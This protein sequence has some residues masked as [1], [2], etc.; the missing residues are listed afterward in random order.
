MD[1]TTDEEIKKIIND[2]IEIR[3]RKSTFKFFE[4]PSN[5]E[6]A[7]FYLVLAFVFSM[8]FLGF[9]IMFAQTMIDEAKNYQKAE[10]IDL[11]HMSC[12]ELKSSLTELKTS[13]YYGSSENTKDEITA[14][15]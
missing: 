15:C 14:R 10:Q 2:T 8:I 6:S 3:K 7:F 1:M 5:A 13:D 12:N 9:T 4:N 11:K